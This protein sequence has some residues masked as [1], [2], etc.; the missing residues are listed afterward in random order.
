M[1]SPCID[2]LDGPFG[3]GRACSRSL[4]CRA[5]RRPAA[6]RRPRAAPDRRREHRGSAGRAACNVPTWLISLPSRSAGRSPSPREAASTACNSRCAVASW[7]QTMAPTPHS[8]TSSS[9]RLADHAHH[10]HGTG[11]VAAYQSAQPGQRGL[12]RRLADQHGHGAGPGLGVLDEVDHR[13]PPQLAERSRTEIGSARVTTTGI[14]CPG[15]PAPVSVVRNELRKPFLP[16]PRARHRGVGGRRAP[17]FCGAGGNGR[18]R[19]AP[20]AHHEIGRHRRSWIVDHETDHEIALHAARPRQEAL[21]RGHRRQGCPT[22]ANAGRRWPWWPPRPSAPGPA[23]AASCCCAAPPAPAA[24]RS[25]RPPPSMPPAHGM[26]VLR[27]RCSPGDPRPLRRRPPTPRPGHEFA[28][29][30]ERRTA[31]GT[32]YDRSGAARLWRLLR[33][34]AAEAP[35]LV[36]VDDVHLADAPSRRWLVEAA[37]H[38]DRLPVAA[39]GDRAQPVRHRPARATVSPTPSRP[40]SSAPTPC[41]PLSADSATDAGPFGSSDAA[42]PAMDRRLRTGRRGQ[43]AAAA[44]PAGRPARRHPDDLPAAVPET[45]AALYP[46]AYPAA[47]SGGWTAP[48]RRPRRSPARSPPW[49]RV[50]RRTQRGDPASTDAAP[51][52]SPGWRAPTRPGSRA[53]SPR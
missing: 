13:V 5:P 31:S 25:W 2:V 40:P 6:G 9:S 47:V 16:C 20:R 36:A 41:A 43:P 39:G 22:F 1:V 24:P 3:V 27:A 18:N 30:E 14:R 46:G 4:R 26:R 12:V 17:H 53:G 19:G 32:A 10:E 33:A 37:R 21:M 23:P 38:V 11:A 8:M 50:G 42:V 35:L 51:G 34:Y 44:R 45:C 52:C 48:G 7:R 49:T 29:A 15:S 28:G